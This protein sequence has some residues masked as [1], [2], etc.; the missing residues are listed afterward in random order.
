MYSNIPDATPVCPGGT[1][2]TIKPGDALYNLARRFNT[3]IAAI[4]NANPGL[5]PTN[6][7]LGQTICIPVAPTGQ[8]CPGGFIYTVRSGDTFYSI[9]RRYGVVVPALAA[10]NPDI[11][12]KAL[13]AGQQ[14]CIPAAAPPVACPGGFTYTVRSG[15]TIYSIARRYGITVP[16]LTT[17]NPN[18][19]PKALRVGQQLCIPAA[20]PPPITCPGRLYT[21]QSGDT[22]YKI[23]RQ[24]GY[25]LDALLEVNPG[26]N[27]NAL[28]VG[29]TLCLP[30]S[31]GGGPFPCPAGSIYI[32]QAGDTLYSIAGRRG[33]SLSTL[34]AANPQI[35]DITKLTVGD[36]VCIPG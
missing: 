4:R 21:I 34:L 17:A 15:D 33:I 23:A 32:I 1:A 27:P 28:V 30:P 36:P 7:Q 35:T 5:N 24:F 20:A 22:L 19:A 25:T 31:P 14:L 16:A 13:R 8:P 3:T 10:A 26:L 9:S 29:Q 2:Y 18:I 6:L 11:D 12:P